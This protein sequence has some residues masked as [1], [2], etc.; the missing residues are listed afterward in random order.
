[1]TTLEIRTRMH[2]R[3]KQLSDPQ[4]RKLNDMFEQEFANEGLVPEK[5]LKERP[6][7]LRKGSLK[8]MADDFDAPLDCFKDCMPNRHLDDQR[9][10]E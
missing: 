8:Y 9:P 1:M 10:R 4:L 7:G 3:I 6:I 5:P 2:E